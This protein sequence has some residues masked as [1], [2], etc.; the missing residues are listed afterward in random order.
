MND[1]NQLTEHDLSNDHN[2]QKEYSLAKGIIFAIG[3]MA[4][5]ILIQIIGANWSTLRSGFMPGMLIGV[6]SA[7]GYKFG[8][9][10]PYNVRT[11]T[12]I[13]VGIIG[14]ILGHWLGY[15]RYFYVQYRFI[16]SYSDSLS[17]T[18]NMMMRE[19]SGTVRYSQWIVIAI[20]AGIAGV[21]AG[22]FLFSG[23]NSK[24]EFKERVQKKKK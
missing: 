20:V 14:I 10:K 13:T 17:Y 22:A 21:F 7:L 1:F 4:L 24:N 2:S 8:N 19:L 5:G 11:L 3:G 23:I 12:L 18:W 9:G 16:L 6:L 15:A